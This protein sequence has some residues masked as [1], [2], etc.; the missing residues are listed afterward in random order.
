M[1]SSRS[2][3]D[4]DSADI[5]GMLTIRPKLGDAGS[6]SSRCAQPGFG[7]ACLAQPPL[8]LATAMAVTMATVAERTATL[9]GERCG[10]PPACGRLGE[11][12]SFWAAGA[13]R[14]LRLPRAPVI[15]FICY[16][17]CGLS[18]L[19]RAGY[20]QSESWAGVAAPAQRVSRHSPRLEYDQ[21]TRLRVENVVP[22]PLFFGLPSEAVPHLLETPITKSLTSRPRTE[23][24]SLPVCTRGICLTQVLALGT[25]T[26]SWARGRW[27]VRA[28]R[29]SRLL[30]SVNGVSPRGR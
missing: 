3:H 16:A 22:R 1:E 11:S 23:R 4:A 6:D 5:R 18:G 8:R 14:L 9:R 26:V 15:S 17:P 28:S 27:Q 29:S 30:Q 10:R 19:M 20:S 24:V 21:V 2:A 13:S 12:H 7:P 25:Y